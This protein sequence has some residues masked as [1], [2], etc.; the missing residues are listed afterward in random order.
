MRTILDTGSYGEY[1]HYGMPLVLVAVLDEHGRVNVST[2]ASS[3]PLPGEPS[4]LVIGVL[5][6]NLTSRLIAERGEFSINLL[7]PGMWHIARY[8]GYTTGQDHD[9]VAECD[10]HTLPAQFVQTPLIRE[11]PL[12]IECVVNETKDLSDLMLFI[13]EIKAIQVADA[14]S[15]SRAGV[16]MG[17]YDPLI[18]AFGY[19]FARGQRVGPS[20]L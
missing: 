18:Y 9:K 19:A 2:N 17:K 6:D 3:T 15:N 7:T 8:C 20:A 13:A 12:N 1:L 10:L 11:C 14:W 4:R 16:D 5:K